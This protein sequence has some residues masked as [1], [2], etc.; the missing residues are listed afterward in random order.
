M[1][2]SDLIESMASNAGISKAAAGKALDAMM[3]SITG[4][5]M[6]GGRVSLVGF[7]SFSVSTRAARDGRNPQTGATI[8]IPARKVVKFKA[9]SELKESVN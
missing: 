3:K 9:G 6:T 5:L 1:N 4:E 7:G 2:K 8:K